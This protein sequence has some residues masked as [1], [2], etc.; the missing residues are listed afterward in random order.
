MSLIDDNSD[1]CCVSPL[2]WF[3]VLPTQTT[4]MKTVN[5]E[6]QSLTP[7][8]EGAPLV[9]FVSPA[10]DEYIDLQNT[11]L[12][13]KCKVTQANGENLRAADVVAPINNL[14]H[15]LW[16]N[17]NFS[18][19]GRMISHSN[20]MNGYTSTISHLIHDS[21]E[22]AESERCMQLIYKD[23]P[24]QMDVTEAREANYQKK[25][26]GYDL[27]RVVADNGDVTYTTLPLAGVVG[28]NG[29]HQRY[30]LTKDSQ[31]VE[32]LGPLRIDL[33]EQERY[34]PSGVSMRLELQRQKDAY[35]LMAPDNSTFKV[36]IED[37]YL[38]LRKVRP[39]PGVIVG[40]SEAL[41]KM[42]AKYPITRKECKVITIPGGLRSVKRDNIYLGQLPKRVVI[43]MVDSS[44]AA[45]SYSRNPY[46]FKTFNVNHMQL[47]TDNEP[48]HVRPL[49]PDLH[50][51]SY[52][53]C[54]ETLYR[55]LNRMDGE[56]S[57]IIKRV[58]W[59]KGYA[60][61]AFDLTPDMD[62]ED[63]YALIKHGNLSLNIEFSA[64][65]PNA[66]DVL[67][68]AEFDNII[69]ITSEGNVQ[70]DYI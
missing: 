19:G 65:L 39:S 20:N 38:L 18:L 48:V 24:N 33:C 63:H 28:N 41:A 53:H 25:I 59:D 30:L 13:V 16:K 46:N 27:N 51:N 37:A 68:Y 64:D 11:K 70:H 2:E 31:H 6:Q 15:S 14:F 5:V 55:G 23:T 1:E 49:K 58:D 42:P 52:L 66:I 67:V 62:A 22:S 69:E 43:A 47:F 9:F 34:L 36:H 50:H 17:I 45:G 60:L 21:E 4:I 7:L 61:F 32:M 35:L 57:N 44:A 26:P 12:Y 54:Y 56:K 40:H 8:R 3:K 29:L 10:T